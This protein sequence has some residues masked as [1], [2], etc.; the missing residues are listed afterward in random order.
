MKITM[1]YILINF[2]YRIVYKWMAIDIIYRMVEKEK[3]HYVVGKIP[4]NFIFQFLT[5]NGIQT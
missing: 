2:K 5:K 3:I 4:Q 1:I